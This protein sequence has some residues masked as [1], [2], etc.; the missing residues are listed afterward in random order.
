M[1]CHRKPAFTLIELL[2]S[3]ALSGLLIVLLNSQI[4]SSIFTD[5]KIKDQLEYRLEIEN[6]LDHVG[7][8]VASASRQP[9]GHKSVIIYSSKGELS[10]HVKRFGL[11]T[12]SQQLH[13]VDVI[14][15]FDS[16]G[17][18]RSIKSAEGEYHRLLSNKK[19]KPQIKNIAPNIV[20]LIIQTDQFHKSKMFAL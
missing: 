4:S 17:I 5:A 13:G 12:I 20:R 11:S 8:D 10:L 2:V 3:L 14:W 9:N 19:I 1:R 15:K 7:A 18:T 6:I 16:N